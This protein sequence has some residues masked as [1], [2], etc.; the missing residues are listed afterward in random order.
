[1]ASVL[2]V[3]ARA[4]AAAPPPIRVELDYQVD[5]A[6][7]D[8]PTGAELS[9]AIAAQLAADP[10]ATTPVPAPHRV[11]AVIQPRGTG[12]E[13]GSHPRRC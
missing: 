11:K 1:M 3:S 13:A 8:C 5:P 9:R 4:T 6:L 12:T 10:F 7:T 2:F